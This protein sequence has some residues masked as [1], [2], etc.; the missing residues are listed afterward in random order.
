MAHDSSAAT[1]A[2]VVMRVR[3]GDLNQ[4]RSE[5]RHHRHSQP[6]VLCTAFDIQGVRASMRCEERAGQVN[7]AESQ[8]GLG[9]DRT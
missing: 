1:A 6:G 3:R 8:L 2:E 4:R 9:I 5:W 7:T